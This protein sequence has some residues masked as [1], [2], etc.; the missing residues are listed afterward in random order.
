MRE[1]F[2]AKIC[3]P[4]CS[5]GSRC[6]KKTKK[7]PIRRCKKNSNIKKLNSTKKKS[8]SPKSPSPKKMTYARF[9]DISGKVKLEKEEYH[10]VKK[11][12][13]DLINKRIIKEINSDK[14]YKFGDII[15]TDDKGYVSQPFAIIYEKNGKLDYITDDHAYDLPSDKRISSKLK[16]NNIKYNKFFE[17]LE[18]ANLLNLFTEDE[19]SIP[20]EWASL[21][22]CLKY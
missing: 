14:K 11:D 1:Q 18:K 21:G 13:M 20:E 15:F 12:V 9:Y 2:K 4:R 22:Y 17:E 8:P 7:F 6:S 10:Y 16:A 19:E 3:P 5:R